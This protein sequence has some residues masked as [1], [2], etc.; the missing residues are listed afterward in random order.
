MWVGEIPPIINVVI[1]V[2]YKNEFTAQYE[3]NIIDAEQIQNLRCTYA[4][5]D[6]DK[7]NEVEFLLSNGERIQ[8]PATDKIIFR[9]YDEGR[10]LIKTNSQR[11]FEKAYILARSGVESS[12]DYKYR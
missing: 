12:V 2:V 10:E 1:H 9:I 11:L 7:E 6:S 4:V 5:S 3:S 8:F